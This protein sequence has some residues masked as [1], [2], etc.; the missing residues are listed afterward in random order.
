[1]NVELAAHPLTLVRA[2]ENWSLADL[3]RLLQREAAREDLRSGID[4]NRIWKWENRRAE[5][6]AEHQLL[7]A[8]LLG[9]PETD[10]LLLA[11]PWWLPAHSNVYSFDPDGS[12]AALREA[13]TTRMDRRSFLVL[14]GSALSAGAAQWATTEPGR[15]HSALD[16]QQVDPELLSWL[17]TTATELQHKANANGP[18]VQDLLEA[19]LRTMIGLISEARYDQETGR[20]LHLTTAQVA[21]SLGWLR[22]DAA[23]H[24][25]AQ[26]LW[27][28]ALHA[29]H[30]AGDRDLGAGILSDLAYACTWLGYPKDAV[31]ILGHAR[32]RTTAPAARSLLDLRRARALAVLHDRSG[33]DRALLSANAELERTAPGSAPGWV[34]WMSQAD[35]SADAGRCW[36]DLGD[37][38]R[39]TDAIESGLTQLDPTRGRTR[40]VF[41]TY[42]SECDL[43]NK[44]VGAA[45]D[46]ARQALDMAINTKATRCLDLATTLI[47]RFDKRPEAPAVELRDYA[48]HRLAA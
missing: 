18:V 40:T 25:A 33:V 43:R 5:P 23:R 21:Q 42:Q 41:L 22:F 4:R 27:Q 13:T 45:A 36:L 37:Q 32:S 47:N 14:A 28:G 10:V 34:S 9:V 15:L 48:R 3:A 35:L 24:G 31:D 44:D 17:E 11:W 16:G 20:R 12:R 38:R 7:L 2:R 39:A 30:Q 6:C 26:R 8:R 19:L 1:M 29:A 46:H